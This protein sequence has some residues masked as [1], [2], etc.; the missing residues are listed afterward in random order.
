[1]Q[2]T[3]KRIPDIK[4]ANAKTLEDLYNA[5][6][7]KEKPKKLAQMPEV[8]EI[9][10]T[11]PNVKVYPSRRTPVHKEKVIGRW[12]VI[13]QELLRRDLPVFGSRWVNAKEGLRAHER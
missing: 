13:E 1:M 3:G 5:V 6:K 12:K 10:Q 8:Q 4:A 11:I 2:L 9:A 7:V